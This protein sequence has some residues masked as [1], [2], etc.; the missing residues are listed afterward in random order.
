ME[1]NTNDTMFPHV[2]KWQ[3]SGMTMR[4]YAEQIGM[5]KSKFEYWIRKYRSTRISSKEVSKFIEI[6]KTTVLQASPDGFTDF[7]ISTTGLTQ[8]RKAQVELI[9]PSGLQL[10]IY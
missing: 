9:L 2:I 4:A 8:P 1:K 5:A 3:T 10:N 7:S 6:G